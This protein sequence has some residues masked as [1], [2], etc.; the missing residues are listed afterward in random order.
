[1]SPADTVRR[2]QNFNRGFEFKVAHKVGAITQALNPSGG[3][4]RR[5]TGE[6]G[7]LALRDMLPMPVTGMVE[8]SVHTVLQLG[9]RVS[10]LTSGRDWPAQIEDLLDVYG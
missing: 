9:R 3:L 8:A 6:P 1:M 7:L 2:G 10:I 4:H 5:N